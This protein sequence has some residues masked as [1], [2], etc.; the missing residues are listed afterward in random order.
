[1][2]LEIRTKINTTW[3]ISNQGPHAPAWYDTNW[4]NFT[5]NIKNVNTWYRSGTIDFFYNEINNNNQSAN[6]YVQYGQDISAYAAARFFSESIKVEN[7][8]QN[9]DNSID[10]DITLQNGYIGGSKTTHAQSGW[11]CHATL[12][13][14]GTNVLDYTGNTIDTYFTGNIKTVKQHVHLPP[15]G[16]SDSLLM[17]WHVEYPNGESSAATLT[18]GLIL[19]NPTPPD[20]RPNAVRIN[21]VWLDHQSHHGEIKSRQNNQWL[22][23][24]TE[25]LSSK[26]QIDAGHNRV[27]NNNNF[28]QASPMNGGNPE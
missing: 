16:S 10:A 11:A 7:E 6:L 14:A 25:H 4:D 19:F 13:M 20:Y 3:E 8:I 9:S 17:R 5:N 27:R 28:K 24:S 15:Q 1:M 22:D 18:F 2:T 26:E 12:D 23:C 21:G